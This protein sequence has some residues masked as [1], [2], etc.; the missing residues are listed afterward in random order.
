[1]R[2][3]RALDFFYDFYTI[4]HFDEFC[5]TCYFKFLKSVVTKNLE[6]D[7]SFLV[8]FISKFPKNSNETNQFSIYR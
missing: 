4:L 7:F 3:S 8:V 6:I 1:M 5:R 2:R